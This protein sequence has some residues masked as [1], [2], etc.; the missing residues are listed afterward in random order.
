MP[1]LDRLVRGAAKAGAEK[2]A[3]KV[4]QKSAI[5]G[6]QEVL[7]AAEREANKAKFLAESKDPRRMYHTTA[8]DFNQF[9]RGGSSQASFVTPEAKFAEDFALDNFTKSP[10]SDQFQ[11]GT[12]TMPVRVQVKNPFDYENEQHIENL[13]ALARKRFPGNQQV[14][15]EI[16]AMGLYE[17]NWPSVE[18]PDIQKLIKQAGH[19]AFYASER[20]T[21]NL[22]VYNPSSIKSD[23]GNVGT[24]DVTNPDINR[25]KGGEVK[26]S[27]N[28]DTM[29]LETMDRKFSGGGNK[30]TPELKA[31]ERNE[32]YGKAA[33]LMQWVHDNITSKQFGYR[34]PVTEMLSPIDFGQAAKALEEKSYGRPMTTMGKANVP[35]LTPEV[36]DVASQLATMGVPAGKVAV[37]GAKAARA[38]APVVEEA[39]RRPFTPMTMTIEAVSPH[40]GQRASKEFREGLTERLLD[41]GRRGA[42][43]I[44]TMG[45]RK[46][47]VRPAQ[48]VFRSQETG[49]LETNP[50]RAVDIPGVG[51]ISKN[52]AMRAEI[53]A[54]NEALEQEA[55]AAHRFIPL[56]TG[57]MEDASALL[58]KPQKG[59]LTPEQVVQIS[60]QLGNDMAVVH[61]PRLGGVVVYPFGSANSSTRIKEFAMAEKAARTLGQDMKIQPGV[62]RY[63]KD[64]LYAVRRPD[65]YGTATYADLGAYSPVPSGK[66]TAQLLDEL[67]YMEKQTFPQVKGALPGSTPEAPTGGVQP[68]SR[69]TGYPITPLGV[70]VEGK[71]QWTPLNTLT[72]ERGK[73]LETFGPEFDEE[74]Q[75]LLGA[76]HRD[77]PSKLD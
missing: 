34:N 10:G 9:L 74:F 48:G 30:G 62:A 72:G 47:T 1:L 16:E 52:A 61:N 31:P 22:G 65:N 75:R 35:M 13:K 5:K 68:W 20:G 76:W 70:E 29:Y 3:E 59:Q 45:G 27:D 33:D 36:G 40:L 19:D 69:S 38:A 14:L 11:T 2:V 57:R 67:K 4:A 39:V 71:T 46:T 58:I 25:A 41:S 73:M 26:L 8:K 64:R 56:T 49:K 28:P 42:V 77:L 6:T 12:Q 7:P 17:H 21:K 43:D 23:L 32:Y 60:D 24:Y 37:K 15:D 50:M 44:S 66:D 18:H 63:D 54:K 55:A 53:A 51:D